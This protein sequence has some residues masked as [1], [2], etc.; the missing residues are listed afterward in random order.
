M[1]QGMNMELQRYHD[2]LDHH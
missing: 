1:I 2:E